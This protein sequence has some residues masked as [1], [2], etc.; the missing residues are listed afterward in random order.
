MLDEKIKNLSVNRA[1]DRHQGIDPG[2]AQGA[3]HRSV[4][5]VIS[6]L[7]HFSSLT[8]WSAGMCACHRRIDS[9]FVNE[10]Q[11]LDRHL[12]LFL[13]ERGSLDLIGFVVTLR[14][15]FRDNPSSSRARQ[16]VGT[17]AST[18]ALFFICSRSSSRVASGDSATNSVKII[19][20][21]SFKIAS[22]PPPWG[23]GAISPRSRFWRSSL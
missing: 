4:G 9:K 17:L 14:L 10:N 2:E 8:S 12:H 1:F 3:N 15:F 6:R 13:R 19:K 23:N 21:S 11:A 7:T 18:R 20:W 5:L 22:A 16:I